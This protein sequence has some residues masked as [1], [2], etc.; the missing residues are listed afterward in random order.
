M[1]LALT[2]R[3]LD[4]TPALRQ[5]VTRRLGKLDRLLHDSILSAQVVLRQEKHRHKVDVLVQTR[6][7]HTLSGHGED[8]TWQASIATALTKV[9]QQA[10][11]LK[12]KWEGRKWRVAATRRRATTGDV[13]AA[14]PV[15]ATRAART[16]PAVRK[17]AAAAVPVEGEAVS[18][19][20]VIRVR[21]S[22]VT[23]PMQLEDAVLRV[24][25][26][27][28]SVL[29]FRDASLD[30]V[31]VLVRRADGHIGLVDPDA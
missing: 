11:R 19:P 22:A 16:R 5:L 30:R 31:Q 24:D 13:E 17:R 27:P 23:K 28:G 18:Q 26:Q 6:G 4:I 14:E 9:E 10:A 8:G 2:G 1:R 21:R 12:G 20:R 7:D 29:V 3:N 25:T 15:G